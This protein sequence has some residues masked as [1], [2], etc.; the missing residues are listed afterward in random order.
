MTQLSVCSSNSAPPKNRETAKLQWCKNQQNQSFNICC[1]AILTGGESLREALTNAFSV[2]EGFW[3]QR[4][5][6]TDCSFGGQEQ[7]KKYLN[8]EGLSKFENISNNGPGRW[9]RW[10]FCRLALLAFG[11]MLPDC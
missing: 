6:L 10:Y 2:A 4:I 5:R 3:R 9:V 7:I 1:G 8:K 11:S